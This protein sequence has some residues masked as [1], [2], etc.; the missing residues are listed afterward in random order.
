[1]PVPPSPLLHLRLEDWYLSDIWGPG[2]IP[3]NLCWVPLTKQGPSQSWWHNTCLWKISNNHR[4]FWPHRVDTNSSKQSL[5]TKKKRK[6]ERVEGRKEQSCVVLS[7]FRQVLHVKLPHPGEKLLLFRVKQRRLFRRGNWRSLCRNECLSFTADEIP[8]RSD[9]LG[10]RCWLGLPWRRRELL[11]LY[12]SPAE[13]LAVSNWWLGL[14]RHPPFRWLMGTWESLPESS[15]NSKWCHPELPLA[16][17][18]SSFTFSS[19]PNSACGKWLFFFPC[20]TLPNTPSQS[21][22]SK[23]SFLAL[24]RLFPAH[25]QASA[26]RKM[27]Y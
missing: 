13:V 16:K 27:N 11:L 12:L 26:R 17:F 6:K 21:R 9:I 1:M 23:G 10:W 15:L 19:H 7:L 5:D 8:P 18:H 4:A 3:W 22:H 2:I 24:K 25:F 14:V 20:R